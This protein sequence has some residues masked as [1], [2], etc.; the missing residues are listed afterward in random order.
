L[1]LPCDHEYHRECVL[2]FRA[3]SHTLCPLC[4]APL[5]PGAKELSAQVDQIWHD[6]E[7]DP[8]IKAHVELGVTSEPLLRQ[9][10]VEEPENAELHRLLGV[11]LLIM[12]PEGR[13]G[14]GLSSIHQNTQDKSPAQN[15]QF[16]HGGC[17]GRKG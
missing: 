11:A 16:Q 2:E 7:M 1:L 5:P 17:S 3:H 14:W 8:D 9:M 13:P 12:I 15:R 4:R 6:I 10:L